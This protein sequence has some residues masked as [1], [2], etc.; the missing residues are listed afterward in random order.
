MI[1]IDI[2]DDSRFTINGVA[3]LRKF[4]SIVNGN[5]ISIK[6]I[7]DSKIELASDVYSNFI[8]NSLTYG[9]AALLQEALVDVL[10]TKITK[11]NIN[12]IFSN[13]DYASVSDVIYESNTSSEIQIN[14]FINY[15]ETTNWNG[16]KHYTDCLPA[17]INSFTWSGANLN[18]RMCV[19]N[20]ILYVAEYVNNK[21]AMFSLDDM[22]NPVYITSFS[23][24]A[25]PR[26]VQVLG[27][28]VIVCCNGA[29]KI[30][31]YDASAPASASLTG[32]ITTGSQPKM[33]EIEGNEIFVCC[34]GVSKVEKYRFSLP[35]NGIN[36]FYSIKFSMINC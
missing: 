7:F 19:S 24:S 35:T 8:I 13:S 1:V 21:I 10:F 30:E 4:I 5:S 32:T 36:G 3:Y 2:L 9:S 12:Y 25:N 6:N 18:A 11:N 33:F 31:F 28:Y 34:S 17:K 15:N 29:D 23:T 27:R 26:H 20:G 16:R 14:N 22:R